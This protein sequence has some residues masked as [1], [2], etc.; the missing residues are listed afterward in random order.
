MK[1][2]LKNDTE[3]IKKFF[4][5]TDLVKFRLKDHK[6][7]HVVIEDVK[8]VNVKTD[9]LVDVENTQVQKVVKKKTKKTKKEDAIP[10]WS[11]EDEDEYKDVLKLLMT[12]EETKSFKEKTKLKNALLHKKYINSFDNDRLNEH[13]EYVFDFN[14]N[15][16]YDID[17]SNVFM[18]SNN[19][20]FVKKI[21][22]PQ[23]G[24]TGVLLFHGVGV[25]KTCSAIQI[26]EN[27]IDFFDNKTL[28]IASK[29]LHG[30]FNKELFDIRK[31]DKKIKTYNG[32]IGNALLNN[33]SGWHKMSNPELQNAVNIVI[34]QLFSLVGY[35]KLVNK[36]E[37]TKKHIANILRRTKSNSHDKKDELYANYIRREFSDRVIIIDEVHNIRNPNLIKET[38]K[39]L[40][41][42]NGKINTFVCISV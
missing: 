30:N 38:K 6:V 37:K 1:K 29:N 32:C 42:S 13:K 27:F 4:R 28:I 14:K 39:A 40:K 3:E 8:T 22:S 12:Y 41:D 24:N 26:A 21:I 9:T 2:I 7:N 16:Q 19:Q 18:L 11:K 25:G 36:I 33:I 17:K 20:K 23:T 15:S 34:K 10:S 5:E 31:I 35:L